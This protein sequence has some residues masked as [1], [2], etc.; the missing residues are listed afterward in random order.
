MCDRH[1]VMTEDVES[2]LLDDI[3]DLGNMMNL[4]DMEEP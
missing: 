4:S 2:N 1:V 3:L